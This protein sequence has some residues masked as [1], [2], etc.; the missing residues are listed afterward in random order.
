MNTNMAGFRWVS[1]I[2]ASFMLWTNIT[3]ALE[4]LKLPQGPRFPI[5][6]DA[7]KYL[8]YFENNI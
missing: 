6:E 2:F 1:K 8:D 5:I 7:V 3:S 4:G